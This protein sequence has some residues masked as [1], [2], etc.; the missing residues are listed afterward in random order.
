[1]ERYWHTGRASM[2][3]KDP[4]Y[5]AVSCKCFDSRLSID[6]IQTHD[7]QAELSRAIEDFLDIT[8]ECSPSI[9][10]LKPKFHFLVH[11]PVYIRR[12]GPAILFSTERYES[13]NHVFRLTC[14]HSNRASPSRDSC[15][16]FAAQDMIK[17]IASGG[18]WFS[19]ARKKWVRAG[20]EILNYVIDHPECAQYLGLPRTKKKNPGA[21]TFL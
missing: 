4:E 2:A 9:L 5:R 12:F 10:I 11:L 7:F 8:A 17:H 14:V 20:S 21:C 6:S 1:M 15:Q 3:H 13:F 18:F 16:T 19:S